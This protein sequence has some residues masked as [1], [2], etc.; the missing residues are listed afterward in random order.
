[1]GIKKKEDCLR[2]GQMCSWMNGKVALYFLVVILVTLDT[3]AASSVNPAAYGLPGHV[4]LGLGVPPTTT[5]R[6]SPLNLLTSIFYEVA[7]LISLGTFFLPSGT[8]NN[9]LIDPPRKNIYYI[10]ILEKICTLCRNSPKGYAL[11]EFYWVLLPTLITSSECWLLPCFPR[12]HW[13]EAPTCNFMVGPSLFWTNQCA[14]LSWPQFRN[15]D[16]TQA[17]LS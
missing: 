13:A 6:A 17:F 5:L 16:M 3:V 7:L 9:R 10:P 2:E 4:L 14:S 8:I 11:V 1:M 12:S 15:E